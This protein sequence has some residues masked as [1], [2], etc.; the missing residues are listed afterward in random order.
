VSISLF[1]LPL[2]EATQI[3]SGL[4]GVGMTILSDGPDLAERRVNVTMH[5]APLAHALDWIMRQVDAR[6]TWDGTGVCIVSDEKKIYAADLVSRVYPLRTTKE[7]RLPHDGFPDFASERRAAVDCIRELLRAYTSRV[8][9]SKLVVA[10]E[11]SEL[12]AT[13]SEAAH[14]RIREVLGEIGRGEDMPAPTPPDR[15]EA[16]GKLETIVVCTFRDEPLLRVLGELARQASVNI[17]VDPRELPDG[18]DTRITLYYG[19]ASLAFTLDTIVKLCGLQG[20]AVEEQGVWLHGRRPYPAQGR[21]LWE[22]GLIRSYYVEPAAKA[23]GI[24]TLL[25]YVKQNVT[26]GQ[27]SGALPAISYSPSGRLIAFHTPAGHRELASYLYV[28]LK[29]LESSAPR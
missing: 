4:T 27:W 17:G 19:K 23:L 11:T 8:P 29:S 3:L 21:L 7:Y 6:Y 22:T 20:Y 9:E 24:P 10:D 1:D 13:C 18:A 16:A 28:L 26:P 14:R 2:L 15:P 12:V 25:K 5:N